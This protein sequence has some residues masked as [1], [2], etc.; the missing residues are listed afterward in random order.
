MKQLPEVFRRCDIEKIVL[1]GCIMD[2]EAILDTERGVIRIPKNATLEVRTELLRAALCQARV[3]AYGS[4]SMDTLPTYL[5]VLFG[6]LFVI[7]LAIPILRASLFSCIP[8][9][10][11]LASFLY[12]EARSTRQRRLAEQWVREHLP[13]NL[14][15]HAILD[16]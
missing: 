2:A 6:V 11:L 10:G 5:M 15:L 7:V 4:F 3:A 1:D 16:E 8:F 13:E 9:F 12:T 14:D